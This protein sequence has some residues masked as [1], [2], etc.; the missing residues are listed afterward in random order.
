M[1]DYKYYEFEL[2][3]HPVICAK[4]EEEAKEKIKSEWLEYDTDEFRNLKEI[5][6]EEY[7]QS[8]E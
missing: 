4:S 5:S 2:V 7:Y 6:K 3:Q 1:S 8:F